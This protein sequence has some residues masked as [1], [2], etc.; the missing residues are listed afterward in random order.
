MEEA[1]I[2]R[3]IFAVS[4]PR[5]FKLLS[6]PEYL[7]Q[8]FSP[9]EQIMILVMRHEFI[10]GGRFQVQYTLPDGNKIVASG[11][12]ICIDPNDM[13]SFTW[14]WQPPDIHAG[15]STIVTWRLI[16]KDQGTELTVIHEK[17]PDKACYERHHA[18]WVGTFN[19]LSNF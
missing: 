11:E 14:E 1:L 3:Q 8:W 19:R 5:L 16:E 6:T 15:V 12:F 7:E 18:G 17:I 4:K 9:S 10:K 13:L 2:L